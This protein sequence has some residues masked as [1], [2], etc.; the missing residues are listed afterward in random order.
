MP[1]LLGAYNFTDWLAFA[2]AD[3]CLRLHSW[4]IIPPLLGVY[5]FTDRPA[6]IAVD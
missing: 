3:Y 1:P 4:A 6:F 2:A 5:V